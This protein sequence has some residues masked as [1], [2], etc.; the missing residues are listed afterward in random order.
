MPTFI[1]RLRRRR[2]PAADRQST[3]EIDRAV[4][5]RERLNARVRARRLVIYD[6]T[7]ARAMRDYAAGETRNPF[8]TASPDPWGPAGAWAATRAQLVDGRDP[9]AITSRPDGTLVG[10]VPPELLPAYQHF[11]QSFDRTAEHERQEAWRHSGAHSW[12]QRVG[13]GTD[14]DRVRAAAHALLIYDSAAQSG[15]V[16]FDRAGAAQPFFNPFAEKPGDAWS[17]HAARDQA[18]TQRS[19]GRGVEQLTRPDGTR[20]GT[21]PDAPASLRAAYEQ[22]EPGFTMPLIEMD[23]DI[24]GSVAARYDA[25]LERGVQDADRHGP[26]ATNPYP[27]DDRLTSAHRAWDHAHNARANYRADA[28]DLLGQGE[29]RSTFSPDTEAIANAIGTFELTRADGFQL[30][31]APRTTPGEPLVAEDLT[32]YTII[33]RQITPP[34]P[35]ASTPADALPHGISAE[36]FAEAEQ[37]AAAIDREQEAAED[38]R[39][40]Q[41]VAE[42]DRVA[43]TRAEAELHPWDAAGAALDYD[44]AFYGGVENVEQT[45]NPYD[46][47]V[48]RGAWDAGEQHR[49]S[50]GEWMKATGER[51]DAHPDAPVAYRPDGSE[52]GSAPAAAG[53]RVYKDVLTVRALDESPSVERPAPTSPADDFGIDL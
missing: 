24:R 38:E 53:E 40:R 17:A 44:D 1:D 43:D 32:T 6:R 33:A 2:P 8:S 41:M 48:L 50:L 36:Q 51:S 16:Q 42:A 18:Q 35:E 19:A 9:G 46:A 3:S 14:A 11:Q 4:A 37:I 28:L 30:A 20:V 7:A 29:D 34:P 25:A 15:S 12:E 52:I 10:A 47:G 26:E 5:E 22:A 13:D 39:D 49:R 23:S 27:V 31:P 45:P 21:A